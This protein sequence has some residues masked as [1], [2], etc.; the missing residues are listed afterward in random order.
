MADLLPAPC[1]HAARAL[2]LILA[3]A[4]VEHAS[5]MALDEAGR[6]RLQVHAA[7]LRL[8]ATA[9]AGMVEV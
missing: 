4:R 9:A 2:E 3:A 8:Q 1:P 6:F 5:R 7:G